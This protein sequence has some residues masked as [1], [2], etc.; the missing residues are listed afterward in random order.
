MAG[1]RHR[2]MHA[3]GREP[4]TGNHRGYAYMHGHGMSMRVHG[5]RHRTR[6]SPRQQRNWP[7]LRKWGGGWNCHPGTHMHDANG[8]QGVCACAAAAAVDAAGGAQGAG[9]S[10]LLLGGCASQLMAYF[11]QASKASMCEWHQRSSAWKTHREWS[12]VSVHN[13]ADVM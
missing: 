13:S 7:C 8:L 4:G 3:C 6:W 12:A 10:R 9:P 5:R 1:M 11:L 2:E